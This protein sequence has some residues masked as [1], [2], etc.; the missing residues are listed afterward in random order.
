MRRVLTGPLLATALA[1]TACSGGDTTV[2]S[3]PG[4]T[5]QE[6]SAA[7]A[8]FSAEV[9][10]NF[11][12]SCIE[13]ARNTADGAATDEELTSTCECILGR[14]EQEYSEAE[15]AEF[16]QRLLSGEA[17]EQESGQLV[18]WSTECAEAA[19]G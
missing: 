18:D 10:T 5:T 15:F 4:D 3:T 11:L 2:T 14:V 13:N 19:T 6:P 1:L 7:A 9:R 17:S 8:S 12:D 16:E